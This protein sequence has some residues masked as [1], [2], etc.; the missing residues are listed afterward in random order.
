MIH[1]L[2]QTQEMEPVTQRK[3]QTKNV[4]KVEEKA[5]EL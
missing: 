3:F 4:E 2:Q 5:F 1:V